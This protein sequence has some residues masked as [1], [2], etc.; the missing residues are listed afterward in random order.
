MKGN[1]SC[2]CFIY[3]EP[4]GK[5]SKSTIKNACNTH[6]AQSVPTGWSALMNPCNKGQKDRPH[7]PRTAGLAQTQQSRVIKQISNN[8]F[9]F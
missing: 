4:S 1:N 7:G 2:K 3:S 5:V 8:L 9:N 6:F